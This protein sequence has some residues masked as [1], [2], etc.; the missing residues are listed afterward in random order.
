MK[1]LK[2]ALIMVVS[3]LIVCVCALNYFTSSNLSKTT[4]IETIESDL[5][6]SAIQESDV[7]KEKLA[8]EFARLEIFS[9]YDELKNRTIS[10]RQK[11]SILASEVR[12]E[13]N[14]KFYFVADTNGQAYLSNGKSFFIEKEPY[15]KEPMNGKQ[16]ISDPFLSTIDNELI[17]IYAIPIYDNQKNIVGVVGLEKEGTGLCDLI[18]DIKIGKTGSAFIISNLT[19]T[20]VAYQDKKTVIEG[21]N[22]GEQAKTNASLNGVAL[23]H[24]K[25]RNGESGT[26][27]YLYK[28]QEYLVGYT[29][30]AGT[31]WS[32]AI[33]APEKEFTSGITRMKIRMIIIGIFAVLLS[34]GIAILYSR[35][36]VNPIIVIK[37][38]LEYVAKGDLVMKE[39]SIEQRIKLLA[40]KDE[41]GGMIASLDTMVK[42]L[43]GIVKDVG[44][45]AVQVR[46]GSEQISSTSQTISTGASEQAAS[47]EEM[48]ATME[49][50]ASNIRQNADNAIKTGSIANKTAEDGKTGG[51]AVN[52]AVEAV[53]EIASK[54]NIVEDI[55]SQ[56][57]MLALNAAIEAARA[58]EAG[59]GF[60]VVASEVRKLAERSQVAAGEI[61]QLS[62][63]TLLVT[64]QAGKMI[65][66]VLPGILE[67]S[68]LVE[69]IAVASKEQDNGAQQVSQ[70]IVQLDTVVQ[71]NASA[72]EEMAAMAEELASHAE[73]LVEAMEFFKISDDEKQSDSKPHV[74]TKTTQKRESSEKRNESLSESKSE[75]TNTTE[76]KSESKMN[77]RVTKKNDVPPLAS[78]TDDDFEEF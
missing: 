46:N 76:K 67:T 50:M 71:Q 44:E 21:E 74:V 65:N 32:I 17:I 27:T 25:M 29:Q 26:G 11:A 3:G 2:V 15:F 59:K 49:E 45:S 42:S 10:V 5:E 64:E 20:T 22:I 61:S 30:I 52:E 40:R 47:T 28:G 60:A 54:I 16:Y 38:C 1:S 70:A 12:K 31:H 66:G 18:K 62:Q 53:K 13:E 14:H 9:H 68:Q 78:V 41:I 7:I 24:S 4:L 23:V 8:I 72:S 55:A 36:L 51:E 63:K 48:S 19:G 69:E 73:N 77:T 6:N 37:K 75:E 43:T 35:S 58:G 56:T 33:R 57:N 39:V 34:I